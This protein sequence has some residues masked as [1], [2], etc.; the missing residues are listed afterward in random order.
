MKPESK[1][2]APAAVSKPPPRQ[3]IGNPTVAG[4]IAVIIQQQT[5]KLAKES[6]AAARL[7]S[8]VEPI[9]HAELVQPVVYHPSEFKSNYS[10]HLASNLRNDSVKSSFSAPSQPIQQPLIIEDDGHW[11]ETIDP[12]TGRPFYYHTKSRESTWLRPTEFDS[13]QRAEEPPK[14]RVT[15]DPSRDSYSSTSKPSHARQFTRVVELNDVKREWGHS[16]VSDVEDDPQQLS[17]IEQAKLN[18]QYF[19][20]EKDHVQSQ[21]EAEDAYVGRLQVD[22]ETD[23]NGEEML[24]V[25]FVNQNNKAVLSKQI[26]TLMSSYKLESYAKTNYNLHSKG[27]FFGNMTLEEMMRWTD[28]LH[29]AL[30]KKLNKHY[31]K[32]A[33]QAFRNIS[34]FMG[35]RKSGKQ[36]VSHAFKLLQN[37]IAAAEEFRDEVYCQICKQVTGNPSQE[38]AV[39]GWKLLAIATGVVP[40][41]E[42]FACYLSAFMHNSMKG[43]NDAIADYARYCID[44]LDRTM[45][46]GARKKPPIAMEIDAVQE[47]R[48]I[49]IRVRF[50]DGSFK[51]LSIDSQTNAR[52]VCDM[53]SK[54]L[55]IANDK[56]FALCEIMEQGTFHSNRF[57]EED[58]RILDVMGTWEDTL[59]AT[60]KAAVPTTFKIVFMIRLFISQEMQRMSHDALHMYFIQAWYCL[61]MQYYPCPEKEILHLAAYIVQ[62]TFPGKDASFFVPGF[63]GQSLSR[64]L[65]ASL[66]N[67]RDAAYLEAKILQEHAEMMQLS[68]VEAK[69]RLLEH[70]RKFPIYGST[71]YQAVQVTRVNKSAPEEVYIAVNEWGLFVCDGD[72]REIKK[73]FELSEILTYGYK[74]KNFLMVAGNLAKQRKLNFHTK[75]GKEINDLIVTYINM[76]VANK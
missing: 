25:G 12:S 16:A 32:E 58:E 47:M 43:G 38:S 46:R 51:T 37:C 34:G 3:N 40:A 54:K 41:S 42:E 13:P 20:D 2:Q 67:S 27:F 64:F 8:A 7:E 61:V 66:V 4:G 6:D 29:D 70:V 52:D 74:D 45:T 18:A 19:P 31:A 59:K 62:A 39:R 36:P 69:R 1:Q 44:R 60:Q 22:E 15:S 56:S 49:T 10:D 72:K 35:D 50:L 55:Q 33:V 17:D 65:P 26:E 5:S 30:L 53:L 11:E 57:L 73:A 28:D 9:Y 71:F 75:Y 14:P 23:A 63:L 24:K 68:P 48:L 21:L 76:K